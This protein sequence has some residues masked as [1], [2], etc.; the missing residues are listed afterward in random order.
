MR[1]QQSSRTYSKFRVS[2]IA[3]VTSL[4]AAVLVLAQPVMAITVI[5]DFTTGLFELTRL[6]AGTSSGTLGG[7]GILGGEREVI[8]E[9]RTGTPGQPASATVGT[10]YLAS[11]PE[12]LLRWNEAD[13]IIGSLTLIYDGTD[14]AGVAPGL[15]NVDLTNNGQETGI[16]IGY[17]QDGR[18]KVTINIET[19]DGATKLVST[20]EFTAVSNGRTPFGTTETAFIPWT[21]FVGSANGSANPA[22]VDAIV[23][24]FDSAL[25]GGGGDY[26]FNFLASSVPEP[27]TMA[28]MFLGLAGLGRYVRR[29][30]MA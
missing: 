30:R 24:T 1:T 20:A 19:W 23:F 5:D 15:G 13:Q 11:E 29:R 28:G 3:M 9:W 12:G 18:W 17:W 22:S 7:A 26:E 10:K 25:A 2:A 14:V 27:V 8:L 16:V 21:A 4:A 6:S